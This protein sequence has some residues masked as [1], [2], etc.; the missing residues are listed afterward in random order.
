MFGLLPPTDRNGALQPEAWMRPVLRAAGVYNL[1]WG[2]LVLAVPAT[3]L[4]FAGF[5]ATENAV[6]LWQCIGMIVGVYG[7]GYWFAAADA[8]RHWPVVLVGFLGKL[9]G[10]IG[11]VQGIVSGQLPPRILWTN[12][13]NDLIWL[14]PFGLILLGALRA[15]QV[16]AALASRSP[17][18][19]HREGESANTSED[20]AALVAEG[21]SLVVFLRHAGCTFSREAVADLVASWDRLT[22]HID[23]LVLVWPDEV[24][25]TTAA[26]LHPP[27]LP[28]DAVVVLGDPAG[29]VAAAHDLK[30]GGFSE[31][32][33]T[34]V[35]GPG[36]RACLQEGHGIGKLAGNGFQMPGLALYQDGACVRV[37]RH[38]TAAERPDYIAFVT[39]DD[40]PAAVS[41]PLTTSRETA[42]AA[43]T[44]EAAAS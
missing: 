27:T 29:D 32:F 4:R 24:D 39:G 11:A 19:R 3:T 31:L 22:A 28:A 40:R 13:T 16:R 38:E 5:E 36:A 1:L 12:L 25:E 43:A 18:S 20:L 23:R 41:E 34:A 9:F 35:W 37:R 44:S 2:V 8:Y 10:P 6:P 30:Q 14:V 21:R 7:V 15:A 42:L 26:S 17:D 33:G